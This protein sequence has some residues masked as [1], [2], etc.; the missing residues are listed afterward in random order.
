MRTVVFFNKK[1]DYINLSKN[2]HDD[3]YHSTL[4]ITEIKLKILSL[5]FFL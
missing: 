4:K 2:S 5:L 3:F 1:F